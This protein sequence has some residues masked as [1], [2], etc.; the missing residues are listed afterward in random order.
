MADEKTTMRAVAADG[1]AAPAA[2][3]FDPS[4]LLPVVLMLG[5]SK[6]GI[7]ASEGTDALLWCRAAFAT[8]IAVCVTGIVVIQLK[9]AKNTDPGTVVV[10][11]KGAD[12]VETTTS[13]TVSEYDVA[14]VRTLLMSVLFPAAIITFLHVKYA[15][16]RPLPL[17]AIMM[18]L[19][20]YKSKL[21]QIYLRG[22]KATGELKRPWAPP[23]NALA[24]MLGGGTKDEA[25]PPAADAVA[26]TKKDS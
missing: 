13:Q 7:D 18:P 17:Q 1:P 16:I 10:T 19:T 3:S 25:A 23:S 4:S 6:L 24:D 21:A 20:L 2:P 5:W 12:G 9:A 22:Y 26:A 11:E 8:A 14:Q 15:F